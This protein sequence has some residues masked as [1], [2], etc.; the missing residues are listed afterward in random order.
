MFSASALAAA[1]KQAPPTQVLAA[2]GLFLTSAV[3]VF[4]L[5]AN[6]EFSA[7]L[8]LAVMLQCLA[9]GLLVLQLVLAGKGAGISAK[10]LSMEAIALVCRLSST[11]WL[12]GYLP[13]DATGDYVYQIVDVISLGFVLWLLKE[14]L[15]NP[16]HKYSTEPD[17]FPITPMALVC[18]VLAAVFHADMNARPLFDIL[19]MSGLFISAVA[20]LPQLW[21]ISKT[22]GSVEAFTSHFI[23]AMAFSR[24]LSGVFMWHARGDITCVPW[25]QGYNHAIWAILGAHVLHMLFLG[26]FA[27]YYVRTMV[28]KGID[29]RM[30]LCE[31]SFV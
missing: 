29:A 5:V 28:R 3:A 7:I 31:D 19:W 9:F 30:E 22:G 26:D 12:H 8:T 14:L 15:T 20:V 2:Y 23:A 4:H 25:V 24:G 27:Y 13:V 10:A 11:T 21:L 18:V 17:S 16:L 1:G 6:G